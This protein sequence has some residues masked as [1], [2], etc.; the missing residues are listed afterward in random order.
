MQGCNLPSCLQLW[1]APLEGTQRDKF[2]AVV[3]DSAHAVQHVELCVMVF[4][5][6]AQHGALCLMLFLKQLHWLLQDALR[7]CVCDM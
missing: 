4:E 3:Q 5:S 6:S 1:P 2:T 7:P